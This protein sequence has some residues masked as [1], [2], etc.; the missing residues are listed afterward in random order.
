MTESD[1]AFGQI[2][3]REFQRDFV[4]RQNANAVAPK[5]AGE[6]RQ[7]DPVVLQLNTEKTTRKFFKNGAGYFY[8]VFLTHSTSRIGAAAS[9][10]D[11][12]R[13]PRAASPVIAAISP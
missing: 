6:M 4:A 10:P 8:A 9:N 7:N 2:V 11:W 1:P 5:P 13:M 3:G 12:R